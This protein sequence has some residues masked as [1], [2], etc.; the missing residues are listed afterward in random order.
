MGPEIPIATSLGLLISDGISLYFIGGLSKPNSGGAIFVSTAIYRLGT[1]E[2]SILWSTGETTPSITVSPS[3]TTTYTVTITQGSQTCT[4]EVTINVNQPA[5]STTSVSSCLP[6]T[7]NGNTYAQ[8]GNYT[9][10][11]TSSNGC[12]STATLNLTVN[13]SPN[14]SFEPDNTTYCNN[15]GSVDLSGGLPSGGVYSGPG[16]SNGEFN[17]SAAG[18]GLH[19]ITY[20]YTNAAG[21]SSSATVTYEVAVCTGV[22]AAAQPALEVRPNPMESSTWVSLKNYTGTDA[23]FNLLLM[24]ATGREVFRKTVS[25]EVIREGYHLHIPELASGTYVLMLNNVNYTGVKRLVK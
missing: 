24:D 8:S 10:S 1:Q 18:G 3:E 15:S 19:P 21:C 14:V 16:V 22:E 13:S 20:S 7:W 9:W 25:A 6:Y 17:P 4:S 23:Q 5:T 2:N 12:D 11:G